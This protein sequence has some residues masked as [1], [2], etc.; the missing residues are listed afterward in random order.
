MA[1]DCIEMMELKLNDAHYNEVKLVEYQDGR[2]TEH[3]YYSV[4][5]K[6]VLKLLENNKAPTISEFENWIKEHHKREEDKNGPVGL[7]TVSRWW[8]SD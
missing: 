1:K 5:K 3:T 6:L 7:E 8:N 4:P 2:R